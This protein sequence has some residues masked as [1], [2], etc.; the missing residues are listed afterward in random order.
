M[1]SVAVIVKKLLGQDLEDPQ[2]SVRETR[3]KTAREVMKL[4]SHQISPFAR[5]CEVV[6]A[7]CRL[8]IDVQ[9]IDLFE[10]EQNQEWF[11]KINPK[12]QVPVLEID[13]N[14]F[15]TESVVIC[16]YL[17]LQAGHWGR[18]IYPSYDVL[19]LAKVNE[20]IQNANSLK[21]MY[22]AHVKLSGK[23]ESAEGLKE[24]EESMERINDL[25]F[26]NGNIYMV[27]DSMTLA[28]LVLAVN[29]TMC[30][31]IGQYDLESNFPN[32][33]KGLKQIQK[34]PE[35]Q[36]IENRMIGYNYQILMKALIAKAAQK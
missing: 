3:C 6:A 21:F 4:Y 36:K 29:P 34:L 1:G 18:A 32:L 12:H 2:E 25:H 22:F 16:Q 28:D 9:L 35:W 20:A 24:A 30:T 7:I 31:T 27:G 8:P 19:K 33:A 14:T 11:L 26:K 10:G 17:C 5:L 15:L 13:E 23:P